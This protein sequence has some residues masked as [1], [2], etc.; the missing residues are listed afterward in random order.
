MSHWQTRIVHTH[1]VRDRALTKLD[2]VSLVN[3][4]CEAEREEASALE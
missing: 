3:D 4:I 2:K 1:T